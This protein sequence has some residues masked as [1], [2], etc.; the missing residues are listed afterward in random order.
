MCGI[1]GGVSSAFN[2]NQIRKALDSIGHRGPNGNGVWRDE[3]DNIIL[4][5]VRLSVLDLSIAGHQ[6]MVSKCGRYVIAF[7][8][9]IYN[10]QILR[11]ELKNKFGVS[12]WD[13][14]SDTE[15]LLNSISYFGL[16][17][18]LTKCSGMFAFALWDR[19]NKTLSLVRDKMGEKPLYYG[20]LD[21]KFVFASELKAIKSTGVKLT[22][23]RSS[24][25]LYFKYNYVP[26]PYS[27]YEGIKKLKPGNIVTVSMRAD[28]QNQEVAEEYWSLSNSTFSGIKSTLNL[29]DDQLI[30]KLESTLLQAVESQLI[31]DVP[32]GAFL[33]GGID[34]SLITALMKEV[35]SKPI[36]TYT[37][38]FDNQAYNE[39]EL[40]KDVAKHLSSEHTELYLTPQNAL[41]VI[42]ILPNMYCEPFADSSQIPTYLVGK[43]ASRSVTVCLSG[44]AGDELFGGYNRYIAVNKYWARINKVPKPFRASL[45][46]ILSKSSPA[47]WDYIFSI[48]ERITFSKLSIPN[49]GDKIQK[50]VSALSSNN[51]V[52]FYDDV[53]T[54]WK[55]DSIVLNSIDKGSNSIFSKLSNDF[56][57]PEEWMMAM[58]L[59][60]YLPDDILVKVDRASMA[61]SLETRVPF[62]DPNV[63]NLASRIPLNQKIRDGKGKWPLR[64]L[65]YRHVPKKLIDRPKRGFTLPLADW[66]RGPLKDWAESLLDEKKLVSQGFLNSSR[67]RHVWEAHLL[68]KENNETLLWSVLMF[69][70]WLDNE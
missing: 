44:D 19:V 17:E 61:N 56:N 63:V 54:H 11:S 37:I 55:G 69:Q 70:A 10:H 2:A 8:G 45:S 29:P 60:T 18:T 28:R 38:G 49:P 4:G 14:D 1:I 66:L 53:V 22:I 7:N 48:V 52:D 13:G 65:L 3:L 27:I 57:S 47:S 12:E 34:S 15:S 6:P 62:L 33:S 36:Q 35:N 23:D 31:S 43:L 64:E 41:D 5:H 26:A 21:N 50:L 68:G 39:A 30:N 20:W 58:D 67:I 32:V 16:K 42:P 59:D 9:E 46:H 51:I 25:D 40:A 24:L